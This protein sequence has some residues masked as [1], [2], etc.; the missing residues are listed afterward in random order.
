M[1]VEHKKNAGFPD[2]LGESEIGRKLLRTLVG[3]LLAYAIVLLGTMIRNNIQK[4]RFIGK[5]DTLRQITV[6]AE[7]R[8]MAAP[9]VAVVSFGFSASAP[10]AAEAQEKN[11]QVMNALI[12]KLAALGIDKKDIQT[13]SYSLAPKYKYTEKEGPVPDGFEASQSVTVKIRDLSKGGKVL[14]LVGEAGANIVS[15]LNFAID[16][17]EVYRARARLLALA[18]ARQKAKELARALGVR[19][20]GIVGY[21]ESPDGATPF[22]GLGGPAALERAAAP[23]PIIEPGSNE[24]SVRVS[25]TYEIE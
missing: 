19:F 22:Y 24:I 15:G 17:V 8:V 21:Y 16:D 7:G 25:V 3:I 1:P 10:S 20:V 9:D 12:E 18:R 11:T 4:H 23:A 6:E 5:A 14:A 2:I 13:A